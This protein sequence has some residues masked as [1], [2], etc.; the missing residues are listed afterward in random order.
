MFNFEISGFCYRDLSLPCHERPL[1]HLIVCWRVEF[2]LTTDNGYPKDA[3]VATPWQTLGIPRAIISL[4]QLTSLGSRPLKVN[5][6]A[7][8]GVALARSSRAPLEISCDTYGILLKTRFFKFSKLSLLSDICPIRT[9]GTAIGILGAK[10][11]L[12]RWLNSIKQKKKKVP[13]TS[14]M[15]SKIET[16]IDRPKSVA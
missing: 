9:L 11:K 7:E 3:R 15:C 4:G 6:W 5:L 12:G 8:S 10:I 2:L 16:C 13:V 1:I 14:L